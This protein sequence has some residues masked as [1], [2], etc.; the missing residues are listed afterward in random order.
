MPIYDFKCK[1]CGE[2]FEELCRVDEKPSCKCGSLETE[3]LISSFAVTFADPTD[4]SKMDSFEYRAGFNMEKAKAVRRN[5][6][7]HDHMGV[8]PYNDPETQTNI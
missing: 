7:Q 3:K 4:T 5:A 2:V 8:N 1:K 6:Q